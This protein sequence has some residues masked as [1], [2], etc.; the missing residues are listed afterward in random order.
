MAYSGRISDPLSANGVRKA[1]GGVSPRKFKYDPGTTPEALERI[2]GIEPFEEALEVEYGSSEFLDYLGTNPIRISPKGIATILPQGANAFSH[3]ATGR[4]I[5][6]H[7]K[8]NTVADPAWKKEGWKIKSRNK[9]A[10]DG[11]F[12]EWDHVTLFSLTRAEVAKLSQEEI[13]KL[14]QIAVDEVR[15]SQL[16]VNS[17]D[18]DGKPV[19]NSTGH[20]QGFKDVIIFPLHEDTGN[21]HIQGFINRIPWN[22]D[23]KASGAVEKD[24]NIWDNYRDNVNQRLKD[25]GIDINLA[26]MPAAVLSRRAKMEDVQAAVEALEEAGIDVH[27]E[28]TVGAVKERKFRPAGAD[29]LEQAEADL[30]AEHVETMRRARLIETSLKQVQGAKGVLVENAKLKED[31][32]VAGVEISKR[33]EAIT[34]LEGELEQSGK[35]LSQET[36]RA[37]QKEALSEKLQE[38]LSATTA[39]KD[40]AKGL[41]SKLLG[42]RNDLR[43]ER[44][45]MGQ[46]L[47]EA[48]ALIDDQEK[49]IADLTKD[50]EDQKAT[51]GELSGVRDALLTENKDLM[52]ERD[53]FQS[54]A[55]ILGEEVEELKTAK[56]TAVSEATRLRAELE[57]ANMAMASMKAAQEAIN[58]LIQN[59]ESQEEVEPEG[60][61]LRPMG[62]S[63]KAIKAVDYPEGVKVTKN[64][65]S[66]MKTLALTDGSQLLASSDFAKL[67]KGKL[68]DA[69]IEAMAVHAEREGWVPVEIVSSD[70]KTREKIA[71]A[72]RARGLLIEGEEIGLKQGNPEAE[73]PAQAPVAPPVAQQ[74]AQRPAQARYWMVDPSQ[75]NEAQ[76]KAAQAALNKA[77]DEGKLQGISLKEFGEHQHKS[78]VARNQQN[79]TPSADNGDKPKPE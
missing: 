9:P 17:F 69:A 22:Y 29:E 25:A 36:A 49:S 31:L 75:W 15:Q 43:E 18:K 34:K 21:I 3:P 48:E 35:F 23:A 28:L 5:A 78:W 53:E 51:I 37:D 32:E 41:V 68:T 2:G 56:E 58:R 52:A 77:Q 47:F 12:Y 19:Y 30:M 26:D 46:V 40:K 14:I 57:A 64:F 62:T 11:S 8:V 59:Q 76:T 7:E 65:M 71:S 1:A 10:D 73:A 70:E 79:E 24:T 72:L 39:V 54:Q 50:V 13:E 63:K 60:D 38:R 61:G 66:R 74:T 45:Y 55:K 20:G 44:N 33:D 16:K 6:L 4:D 27:P 42:Q 67:T